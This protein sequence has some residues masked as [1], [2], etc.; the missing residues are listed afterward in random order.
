M[1]ANPKWFK[2]RKYTGWGI[3]PASWQGWLYLLGFLSFILIVYSVLHS[4]G[5]KQEYTIV[6]VAFLMALMVVDAVIIMCRLTK[7]ER[8]TQHEAIAERNAT[9]A[10]VII[11]GI[12]VIF[13]VIVG[14]INQNFSLD[15]FLIVA[16]LCGVLAKGIT[17]W[18][19]IDK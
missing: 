1:F 11:I 4:F 5:V 15:P 3:T 2:R 17:N 8:Q 12:G 6:V 18:F 14:I 16:L 13:Q 7:D 10:M 19:L 9:W